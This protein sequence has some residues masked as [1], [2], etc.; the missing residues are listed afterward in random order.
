MSGALGGRVC[1][2]SGG[3]A[4]L[5]RSAA[6]LLGSEG[7]R[8]VIADR[9]AE[10]GAA[11]AR[12]L[13]E[14]GAEACFEPV[15]VSDEAAVDQL[16]ARVRER[17]GVVDVLVN[18]AGI[19]LREG[20]VATLTRKQWDLT[21][22]VNLTSVYLMSNRFVPLM[23]PGSSIVNVATTGALRA[24]PGT[25]A[26]L[27][28][29]GGVIALSKAMAVSLADAGIRVN[30]VCPGMVLTDEVAA[31][32]GDSRVQAMLDRSGRPLGRGFGE[33]G[34][35]ASVVRFL[36]GPEASYVNGTVVVVDGGASA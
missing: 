27:A 21:I 4:G 28:A 12:D 10:R 14:T 32:T 34:E 1:L 33:P 5:G 11:T 36:V 25:D 13:A 8:V 35:F 26:Y 29:K 22:A 31:R 18:N 30:V 3:A 23:P 16:A 24:V 15:D 20:G 9:D 6:E 17:F 2:I 19:A 7:A